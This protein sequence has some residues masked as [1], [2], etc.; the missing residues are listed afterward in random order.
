M[1]RRLGVV[2][3]PSS[4]GAHTPGLEKAPA[5]VRAAGLVELLRSAGAVVEDYGDVAGSR[6]RPDPE[7]PRAQNASEVVRVAAATATAV[8]RVLAD[9][10]VPLVVGGDCTVTV[11]VVAGFARSGARPALLYVDGGPDL[12]TPR[13]RANG[14]L[15]ATGLAHLLALPGHLPE[16]GGIGPYVPM[17][18]PAEVLVYGHSL[19]EAAHEHRLLTQLGIRHL[20]LE[21]V[22]RDP[23]AAA[24]RARTWAES[25]AAAFLVHLDVDVLQ[26]A[27]APLADV[28]EPF[29]LTLHELALSLAACTAS[30]HF[31]G[32]VLT[33]I[34]PDHVPDPATLRHFL[35]TLIG[36][37]LA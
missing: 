1:D 24:L 28:P 10:R 32:L 5:A 14:N 7:R 12:Y 34:N 4:A 23:T 33:E 30:T 3:V 8:E 17:L 27:G 25:T 2:G 26:F 36:A 16:L 20:P 29:G 19:P 37:G 13:T 22:R 11:G 15:D 31:A 9:A 35:A 6:W 21:E 18:T